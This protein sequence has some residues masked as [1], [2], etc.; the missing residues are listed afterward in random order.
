MSFSSKVKEELDHHIGHDR[1]C[2]LAELGALIT[3]WGYFEDGKWKPDN[4]NPYNM[5]KVERICNKLKVNIEDAKLFEELH[6]RQISDSLRMIEEDM[7]ENKCCKKAFLRGAFLASGSL[8][9][10][11]K[12]YHFEIVCRIKEQADFVKNIMDAL[13]IKTKVIMR[14]KYYIV[15]IKDGSAIV[16]LLN[17]MGAS[18]SLMDME[19]IRILKDMRNNINRRINCEAANIQKTV[20]AAVKQIADIEYIDETVGLSYLPLSLREVAEIRLQD[21][22]RPLKE[23]GEMLNPPLG[24]S[25]VNHRLRKISEIADELRRNKK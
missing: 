21:T 18:V 5:A 6:L 11:A 2:R 7:L 3:F 20:S 10:P 14:K 22:D 4:D 24:K 16:E 8:T 9:D 12:G 15:Y 13:E 25:G 17:I 23:I 1:H 19:N